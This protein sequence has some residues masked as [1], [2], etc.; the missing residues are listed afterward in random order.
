MAKFY[1]KRTLNHQQAVMWVGSQVFAMRNV[2]NPQQTEAGIDGI[3]RSGESSSIRMQNR[4]MFL[5]GFSCNSYGKEIL[6][7]LV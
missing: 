2:F 6:N 3:G 4:R 1:D 7:L 5:T